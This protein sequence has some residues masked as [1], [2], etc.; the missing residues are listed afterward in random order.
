MTRLTPA[1]LALIVSAGAA[2]APKFPI[3]KTLEARYNQAQSLQVEF[4]ETYSGAGRAPKTEAGTLFL[5]KPGRMR[6]EYSSPTA[7]LF[8]SDKTVEH[9][10]SRILV[11]LGVTSRREAARTAHQLDL[12]VPRD[13]SEPRDHGAG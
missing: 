10:V 2:D 9:H 8:V 1:L 13:A 4:S 3:L 11:K 6:W 12:A 7:K 5:R